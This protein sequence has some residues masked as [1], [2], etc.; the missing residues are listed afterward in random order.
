MP[1]TDWTVGEGLRKELAC[2]T[3]HGLESQSCRFSPNR[4]A[5][6][7]FRFNGVHL[8]PLHRRII[9]RPTGGLDHGRWPRP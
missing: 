9:T 2:R 7:S 5:N 3:P 8:G 4:T 1:A 6:G